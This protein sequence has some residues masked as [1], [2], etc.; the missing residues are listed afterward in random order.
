[1]APLVC[2]AGQPCQ[3]SLLKIYA[4]LAVIRQ[5]GAS[6]AHHGIRCAHLYLAQSQAELPGLLAAVTAARELRAAYQQ[7][8]SGT[9]EDSPKHSALQRMLGGIAALAQVSAGLAWQPARCLC[10]SR[11]AAHRCSCAQFSEEH[12]AVHAVLCRP[13]GAAS[14]ATPRAS[15]HFTSQSW[16]AGS[17]CA[18]LIA[19]AAC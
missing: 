13:L 12:L 6:L 11:C 16:T 5:T 18:T 4:A 1:M 8:E 15:S 2:C 10:P 3:R 7:V 14:S 19:M 9:L 17:T